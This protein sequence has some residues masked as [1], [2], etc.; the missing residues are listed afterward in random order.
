MCVVLWECISRRLIESESVSVY[1]NQKLWC[2]QEGAM[3]QDVLEVWE[4]MRRH[5]TNIGCWWYEDEQNMILTFDRQ[6]VC[7]A[8]K[9][10]EDIWHLDK[11]EHLSK[12]VI[13][14]E[15]YNHCLKGIKVVIPEVVIF[16]KAERYK[17]QWKIRWQ[18]TRFTS[19]FQ[20]C[21]QQLPFL[22]ILHIS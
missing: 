6:F 5:P 8:R 16:W 11:R 4:R 20:L 1:C 14:K 10:L 17:L 19:T 9:T 18:Y 2:W 12:R 21:L 13:E 22:W 3:H 15:L 7:K